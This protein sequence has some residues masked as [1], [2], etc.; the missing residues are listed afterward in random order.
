METEKS[1]APS[2]RVAAFEWMARVNAQLSSWAASL[3]WWRL[4]LLFIIVMAAAGILS[5]QLHLRHDTVKVVRNK[6]KNNVDVQIGGP[7]GITIV[8]RR[9]GPAAPAA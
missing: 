6:E 9:A 2:R 5:E 7:G 3:S 1:S 8:R 4:I